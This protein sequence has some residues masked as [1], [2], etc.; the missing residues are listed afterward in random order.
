MRHD[1]TN[2]I[3]GL[4]TSVLKRDEE[5]LEERTQYDEKAFQTL[6]ENI[7]ILEIKLQEAEKTIG[8]QY[9]EIKHL[10]TNVDILI[11]NTRIICLAGQN[12]ENWEI[13][14]SVGSEESNVEAPAE[15]LSIK[16]Q[17]L[18][19][20]LRDKETLLVDRDRQVNELESQLKTALSRMK[21]ISS[22]L[23]QTEAL[24]SIH[25]QD[26]GK[27]TVEQLIGEKESWPKAELNG[28][29]ITSAAADQGILSLGVFDRMAHELKPVMGPLAAVI[30]HHDVAALGE[31]I[32]RFPRRRLVELL[33]I[34]TK[35]L[36]DENLK[37]T[38][39]ERFVKNIWLLQR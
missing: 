1:K 13:E 15:N 4:M 10:K 29:D 26:F 32:E 9:N 16:I 19:T 8:N 37:R 11:A 36:L 20:Q 21:E 28:P 38:I 30:I 14:E 5:P 6:R 25:G 39:R 22:S 12:G 31:S 35:E 2:S 3:D 18:K 7:G 24:G 27:V 17:E 23:R 34:V 33:D